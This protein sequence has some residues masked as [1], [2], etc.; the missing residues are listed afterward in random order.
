MNAKGPQNG[1]PKRTPRN[2]PQERTPN[3]GR[4]M[5]EVPCNMRKTWRTYLPTFKGGSV[6]WVNRFT[7]QARVPRLQSRRNQPSELR[8]PV[9]KLRHTEQRQVQKC[10]PMQYVH[11]SHSFPICAKFRALRRNTTRSLLVLVAG[12]NTESAHGSPPIFASPILIQ[13]AGWLPRQIVRERGTLFFQLGW[14]CS[15]DSRKSRKQYPGSSHVGT[16]Q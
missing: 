10:A 11:M 3:H 9:V 15:L 4:D 5:C 2:G 6:R 16:N 8:C 12:A 1:P 14:F 13:Y 7:K